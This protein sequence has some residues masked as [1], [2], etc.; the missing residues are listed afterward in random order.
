MRTLCFALMSLVSTAVLAQ[1]IRGIG[2]SA[3]GASGV[4][5][6]DAHLSLRAEP[7]SSALILRFGGGFH[8][9]SALNGRT[10]FSRYLLDRTQRTYFGYELLIQELQPGEYLA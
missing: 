10:F 7:P 3:F 5:V 1:P 4:S 2:G 6:G 8:G 9:R